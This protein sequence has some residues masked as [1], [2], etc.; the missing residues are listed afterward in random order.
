M[1]HRAREAR[2]EGTLSLSRL[3]AGQWSP[4]FRQNVFGSEH[5]IAEDW[6]GTT[7]RVHEG[8][9][10]VRLVTDPRYERSEFWSLTTLEFVENRTGSPVRLS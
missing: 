8:R 3:L 10:T 2:F 7:P 4:R 9:F 5:T 6:L 1:I